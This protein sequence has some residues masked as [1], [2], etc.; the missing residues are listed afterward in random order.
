MLKD[1]KDAFGNSGGGS[2]ALGLEAAQAGFVELT[3]PEPGHYT[4][5]DHAFLDAERGALG[6]IEVTE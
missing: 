3:F 2:Q 4:V 5:V 1:G 6:T